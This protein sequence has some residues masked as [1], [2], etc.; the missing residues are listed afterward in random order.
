MDITKEIK[1]KLT[2]DDVKNIIKEHLKTK[3][4]NISSVYFDI[5]SHHDSSDWRGEFPPTYM[6][7]SVNCVGVEDNN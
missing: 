4:F 6:L 2:S 5:N 7:D 1:V 3:G